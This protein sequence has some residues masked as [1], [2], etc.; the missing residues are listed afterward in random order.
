MNEAEFDRVLVETWG[1]KQQLHDDVR[2]DREM[3]SNCHVRPK[4]TVVARMITRPL[5]ADG[6]HVGYVREIAY[7]IVD[8]ARAQ[9]ITES[10][11][12][13]LSDWSGKSGLFRLH[14]NRADDA[15]KFD[16]D[17]KV[18]LGVNPDSLVGLKGWELPAAFSKHFGT[19]R[20]FRWHLDS[21]RL[22]MQVKVPAD[23][24]F[25]LF[26]LIAVPAFNAGGHYQGRT[27]YIT[28]WELTESTL[29][30]AREDLRSSLASESKPVEW[31][32]LAF[33]QADRCTGMAESRTWL[34]IDPDSWN[35]M[36]LDGLEGRLDQRLGS[37]QYGL[38]EEKPGRI[39]I[40]RVFE[41]PG[42]SARVRSL[43]IPTIGPDGR[44][45][46]TTLLLAGTVLDASTD[47]HRLHGEMIGVDEMLGGWK[48]T[49]EVLSLGMD[50]DGRVIDVHPG[51]G[52][53]GR[54]ESDLLGKTI[55]DVRA[56]IGFGPD[57]ARRTWQAEPGQAIDQIDE[58]LV[59]SS[60]GTVTGRRLRRRHVP[61]YRTDLPVRAVE[62]LAIQEEQYS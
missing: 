38:W 47:W 13:T 34:G 37:K 33:D 27:R 24:G 22:D 25:R 59:P 35:G 30:A 7:T 39:E 45:S 9:A 44:C 32:E 54:S 29:A 57:S 26:R 12:R 8:P 55:D 43:E 49:G 2:P 4:D 46:G 36:P 40:D 18:L 56:L 23:D 10:A 5:I 17:A 14:H 48:T 20:V 41:M 31:I 21:E 28:S 11:K 16:G 15:T 60:S 3:I 19:G 62:K 52:F 58:V 6:R 50:A 42:R 51:G 53:L 61:M 1:Q